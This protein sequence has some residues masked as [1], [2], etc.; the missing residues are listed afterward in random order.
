MP[1]FLSRLAG[2]TMGLTPSVQ[3]LVT[4]MYGHTSTP[5]TKQPGLAPFDSDLNASVGTEQAQSAVLTA[6]VRAWDTPYPSAARDTHR[7]LGRS[8]GHVPI[9]T[10]P[11][12]PSTAQA[13]PYQELDRVTLQEELV[14]KTHKNHPLPDEGNASSHPF[15]TPS[16]H[17]PELIPTFGVSYPTVPSSSVEHKDGVSILAEQTILHSKDV[18]LWPPNKPEQMHGLVRKDGDHK[19]IQ[20]AQH[21]HSLP[22]DKPP[23]SDGSSPSLGE[24]SQA[25]ISA[26]DPLSI[27]DSSLSQRARAGTGSRPYGQTQATTH[28]ILAENTPN[29][30]DGFLSQ[31]R[32]P[33]TG[34]MPVH[35][36]PHSNGVNEQRRSI[37]NVLGRAETELEE[38]RT[39]LQDWAALL[40]MQQVSGTEVSH[41]A[42]YGSLKRR[43]FGGITHQ[44]GQDE[45]LAIEETKPSIQVTIGRIEVR[46]TPPPPTRSPAQRTA[47][48]VM[49]LDDYV[50]QRMKGGR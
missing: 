28:Q 14:E 36:Q 43:N 19:N 6:P 2:R 41:S 11:D 32:M 31:Q 22:M 15:N 47:P 25:G 12:N 5:V 7:T 38:E 16:Q 10:L 45:I 30:G 18:P 48:S 1:D 33:L 29:R 24:F 27:Q 34:D 21:D 26:P 46:A 23:Q 49:S 8:Q 9:G 4:P 17:D 37:G 44:M 35:P 39:P 50:N 13:D 20:F 40:P 3:P 42:G